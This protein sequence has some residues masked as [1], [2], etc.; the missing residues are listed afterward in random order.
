[1]Q[2]GANSLALLL[3]VTFLLERPRKGTCRVVMAYAAWPYALPWLLL[4]LLYSEHSC[5]LNTA[6]VEHLPVFCCGLL[7]VFCQDVHV[8]ICVAYIV[9]AKLSP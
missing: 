9:T 6:S 1:M 2:G 4:M 3:R 8:F 7:P 5:K